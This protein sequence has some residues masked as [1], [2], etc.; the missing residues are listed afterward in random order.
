MS[1]ELSEE[2]KAQLP[3]M[4]I[5][6]FYGTLHNTFG[7]RENHYMELALTEEQEQVGADV[8]L[9]TFAIVQS[10][11]ARLAHAK[12]NITPNPQVPVDYL[13]E[14]AKIDGAITA[15]RGLLDTFHAAR[16]KKV[17]KNLDISSE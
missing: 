7:M 1:Q 12:L 8:S 17:F 5:G 15:L 16:Q 2:M 6:T 13:V 11:L 10:M 14:N 9:E 3:T 4:E